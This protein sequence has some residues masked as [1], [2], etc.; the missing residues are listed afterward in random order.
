[1]RKLI[2]ILSITLISIFSNN[3]FS[4]KIGQ[5][6][7]YTRSNT[8]FNSVCNNRILSSS[9]VFCG[10]FGA[11]HKNSSYVMSTGAI[12]SENIDTM[13][14]TDA[15]SRRV[16]GY[17][18]N[19]RCNVE[20]RGG[21]HHNDNFYLLVNNSNYRWEQ[22]AGPVGGTL[23]K[24]YV[25]A[26]GV[27]TGVEDEGDPVIFCRIT[28]ANDLINSPFDI[29]YQVLGKYIASRNGCFFGYYGAN[30]VSTEIYFNS[31]FKLDVLIDKRQ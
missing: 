22:L 6:D 15:T 31:K 26:N 12:N 29:E 24:E 17:I 10:A 2:F 3:A 19:G 21:E 30:Y 8:Q 28:Y 16:P 11:S 14:C 27:S 20:W 7:F 13:V 4:D 23:A 18:E 9:T 25:L 1:M 5:F